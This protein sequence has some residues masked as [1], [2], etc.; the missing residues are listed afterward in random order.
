MFKKKKKRKGGDNREP[1]R[2]PLQLTMEEL[3]EKKKTQQAAQNKKSFVQG[4][5]NQTVN[6]PTPP[7]TPQILNQVAAQIFIGN[8]F[9]KICSYMDREEKKGFK[10]LIFP[11]RYAFG[12]E[13]WETCA[14]CGRKIEQWDLRGGCTWWN[15]QLFITIWKCYRGYDESWQCIPVCSR[16]CQR[17]ADR[18]AIYPRERKGENL[19]IDSYWIFEWVAAGKKWPKQIEQSTEV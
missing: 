6:P 9:L 11:H 4:Q 10:A 8:V 18:M 7:Q 3:I 14:W 2:E 19:E 17:E 13:A 12:K 15:K 16:I 1:G 5:S